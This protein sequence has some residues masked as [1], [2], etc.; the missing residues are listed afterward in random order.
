MQWKTRVLVRGG[1]RKPMVLFF[2]G[3]YPVTAIPQPT[4]LPHKPTGPI[5][6]PPA[7]PE[8]EADLCYSVL[9]CLLL[10]TKVELE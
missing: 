2:Q 1:L 9:M 7:R 5:I 8:T 10:K 4:N 6:S 3:G